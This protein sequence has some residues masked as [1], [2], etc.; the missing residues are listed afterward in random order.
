M[1]FATGGCRCSDWQD[2]A[3]KTQSVTLPFSLFCLTSQFLKFRFLK[4]HCLLTSCCGKTFKV[5][6]S[7]WFYNI[8]IYIICFKRNAG[9]GDGVGERLLGFEG[10]VLVR[11]TCF[12]QCIHDPRGDETLGSS[13]KTR[14]LE[15][16]CGFSSHTH[17]RHEGWR[18]FLLFFNEPKQDAPSP[19]LQPSSLQPRSAA[20]PQ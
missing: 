13:R 20:P 9:Q 11:L 16:R 10:S 5:L 18:W 19:L 12:Q 3:S 15:D 4:D 6:Q 7:L 14:P 1:T 2:V 8:S 17:G